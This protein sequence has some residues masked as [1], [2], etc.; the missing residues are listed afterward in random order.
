[1]YPINTRMNQIK[2]TSASE[3][4]SAELECGSCFALTNLEPHGTL[5]QHQK[6]RPMTWEGDEEDLG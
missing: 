4:A 1:M 5:I 3:S 6:R 2:P